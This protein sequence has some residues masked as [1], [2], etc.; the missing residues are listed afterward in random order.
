MTR[1]RLRTLAFLAGGAFG[2]VV[3]AIAALYAGFTGRGPLDKPTTLVIAKG[4]SVGAIASRLEAE[5]VIDSALMFEIG[6]RLTGAARLLQAGE[7]AFTPA[8]SMREVASHLVSGRTVKRRLT[9]AE[10]MMSPHVL[11]LLDQTEG[12]VGPLPTRVEEG[13]LLP[14]T[15]FY[16]HGDTRL[17]VLDRMRRS[18]REALDVA[19]RSRAPDIAVATRDEALVLASIIE[20]ETGDPAERRR[21]AGVFHNRL[22]IGMRLQSDPTVIYAVTGGARVL[23]RDLT[24]EDL[25]IDSPFNTYRAAGLPP[26]PIANPGRDSIVAALN[27]EKTDLLYFVADGNGG[28]LFA[29]TLE[30]HNRNVAKWRAIQRRRATPGN[31]G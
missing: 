20:K 15:Y 29:K 31:G 22:R 16:S 2:M 9:V 25:N 28:H 19:W 12:L 1:P 4:T 5:R 23:D 27:P 26:A 8:M 21:V 11:M 24:R 6:A 10:G 17:E 3:L 18:A 13:S 14:E 30:E 7:Y